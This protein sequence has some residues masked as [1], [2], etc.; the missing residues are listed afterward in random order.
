MEGDN[1]TVTINLD[2]HAGTEIGL[3]ISLVSLSATGQHVHLD[4]EY[5]CSISI[6]MSTNTEHC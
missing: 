4:V 2:R 6:T 3:M 1:F 5:I